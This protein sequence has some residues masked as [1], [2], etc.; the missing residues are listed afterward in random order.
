MT[1]HRE[2][3][4]AF[5][6]VLSQTSTLPIVNLINMTQP[7]TPTAVAPIRDWRFI[8]VVAVGALLS[9]SCATAETPVS[10]EGSIRAKAFHDLSGFYLPLLYESGKFPDEPDT[11]AYY[12]Y[13]EWNASGNIQTMPGV[14]GDDYGAQMAGYF[15]PPVSGDYVFW[16]SS[17]ASGS[18]YLSSDANPANRKLIA[19]EEIWSAPR[20]WDVAGAGLVASKN[21]S[22]FTATEWPSRDAVR[23]GARITLQ[24]NQAY[25]VEGVFM[26]ATGG[27]NLAVAVQ[28]PD[29]SIDRT[30]PIPGEY[31]SPFDR[32]TQPRIVR[33]PRD[34]GVIA[35]SDATFSLVL[36]IPPGV[37]LTSI[38]W[39]RNGVDIPDSNVARLVVA[40]TAGDNGSIFRAV[41]TTSSGTLVSSSATLHVSTLSS[42]FA[43]GV[44]KF[45]A[46]KGIF[47]TMVSMLLSSAKFIAGTPDEVRLLGAIDSPNNYA[48][49]YGAKLGGFIIPPE[50]GS[51]RFFL[52]SDDG[53]QL[54]L[55]P[56]S[57]EANAVLIA[58]ETTC[59]YAFRE[60]NDLQAPHYQTSLP[61]AL[62]AGNRY[63]YYVLLKEGGGNDYVQ[64]AAR[65]E[66]DTTPANTLKPLTGSW[67]GA[68]ARSST[69]TPVITQQPLSLPQ[70][71]EDTSGRLSVTASVTPEAFG[72]VP[73]FQ[74]QKNGVNIVGAITKTLTFSSANDGDSG[75]YRA[76][77]SAPSGASV[78][79]AEAIVTVVPDT[80]APRILGAG[81]L[82]KGVVVEI[83]I[84]FDEEIDATT[85]IAAN[86]SLSK[87]TIT[88]VRYQG[89]VHVGEAEKLMP[90]PAGPFHGTAVVLT[91]SGLTPGE[92]VTVTALNVADRKGN[93]MALPGESRAVTITPTMKW[94]AIGGNDYLEGAST[95]PDGIVPDP[96]L[97]PDDAVAY[98]EQD[99]DLISSGAVGSTSYEEATFVYE[100]ITGDFDK[101]VRVEYQDPAG[102]V[103]RA[104]LCATPAHDAGITRAAV[105]QG[106]AMAQR[107]LLFAASAYLA[108]WRDIPGIYYGTG[109]S[110]TPASANTWLRMRRKGRAFSGFYSRDGV[111][112]IPYDSH[113]FPRSWPGTEL[114]A[115]LLVGLYYCPEMNSAPGVGG[116]GH[117]T[118]VRFRD[119]GDA[120]SDTDGL[121]N[122]WEWAH[123]L[124]DTDALDAA[125]D[126]DGDGHSN[127]AE[128]MAGTEPRDPASALQITH[129]GQNGQDLTISFQGVPGKVYQLQKSAPLPAGPWTAVIENIPGTTGEIT[130]TCPGA[131]ARTFHRIIV[132]E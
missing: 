127:L 131:D 38:A 22:T 3:L 90:G 120:D 56:D 57:E 115:R 116:V 1:S 105:E 94:T 9:V 102:T 5:H 84:G 95:N 29:G 71:I 13:F 40:T 113:G 86:F 107:Y 106:Y 8:G 24:A 92:R 73:T 111:R 114:P 17:D 128:F 132:Q 125:D 10:S 37:T 85:A 72:F 23:G 6:L 82:M 77:V 43:S 101:V 59:C 54:F 47:G 31:L 64:V 11:V 48:D 89:F 63:A 2:G 55:S 58:E 74:W 80:F 7:R 61:Q 117:S 110:G 112:W 78:T 129:L 20:S 60:P 122:W 66:G 76:V 126:S 18:L 79:T 75:I 93:I 49:D 118:L 130:V 51:Y 52:R 83:G 16:I 27:D 28:A 21:S 45:E 12:P 65:E 99:F 124:S 70:L 67:I 100:E 108:S 119:Y 15:Y 91:T 44:V 4:S 121:P 68:N 33:Q 97:W 81:S 25:Y 62:E 98:N 53:S 26:A 87:G 96:G 36:D 50:T 103:P 42:D 104:G 34:A 123:D 41:V 35:G 46:Y 39:Q 14:Y 69:G 109:S 19:R 32:P 88:D 30:L